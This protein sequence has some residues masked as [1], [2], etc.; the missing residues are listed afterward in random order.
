[1]VARKLGVGM[2]RMCSNIHKY[3]NTNGASIPI[4]LSEALDAGKIHAGDVIILAAFGSGFT[5]ASAA[6]RW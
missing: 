2:G 5:W 3:G 1:M 6:I 4:A